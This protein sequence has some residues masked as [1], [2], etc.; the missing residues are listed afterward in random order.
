M[1]DNGILLILIL[2]RRPEKRLRAHI[3]T[4]RQPRDNFIQETFGELSPHLGVEK[5]PDT[6]DVPYKIC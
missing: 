3:A 4:T 6:L 2:P 5:R 1:R